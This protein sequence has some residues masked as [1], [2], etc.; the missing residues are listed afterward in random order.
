MPQLTWL[1]D[2]QAKRQIH[3]ETQRANSQPT[4]TTC[5]CTLAIAIVSPINFRVLKRKIQFIQILTTMYCSH[6]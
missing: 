6:T 5:S 1:G 3:L 4:T 2:A